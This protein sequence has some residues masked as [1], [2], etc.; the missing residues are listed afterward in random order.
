MI[1]EYCICMHSS[2]HD[3]STESQL[4]VM[5]GIRGARGACAYRELHYKYSEAK[6]NSLCKAT[7][8]IPTSGTLSVTPLTSTKSDVRA[9]EML[10]RRKIS[11]GTERCHRFSSIQYTSIDVMVKGSRRRD[12]ICVRSPFPTLPSW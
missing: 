3:D 6:P 8:A 5:V 2:F 4:F 10:Q 9:T 12:P 7:L 11:I 1:V